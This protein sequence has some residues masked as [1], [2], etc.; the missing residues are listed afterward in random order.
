MTP[1]DDP[2]RTTPQRSAAGALV[3]RYEDLLTNAGASVRRIAGFLGR[4]MSD[5]QVKEVVAIASFDQLKSREAAH[6]FSEAVRAG[7]FFRVGRAG[8]WRDIADQSAFQPLLELFPR[9]MCRYGYLE[10][11]A[12]PARRAGRQAPRG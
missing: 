3:L 11:V 5:E 12:Q 10:R 2:L 6:G 9:L 7:R 1:A 8:Q 4:Q